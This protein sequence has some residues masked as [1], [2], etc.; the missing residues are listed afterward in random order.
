MDTITIVILV[1]I[2]LVVIL[3]N[4]NKGEPKI[5]LVSLVKKPHQ[6]SDWICYHLNIGFNK[7][8]LIFDDPNDD[9]IS[10]A[11]KFNKVEVIL[12]NDEWK[13]GFELLKNWK[14]HGKHL[15]QEVMSRQ[16]LSVEKTLKL[17]MRDELDWLMHIDSDEILYIPSGNSVSSLYQN[18]TSNIQIVNVD[19]Y[20]VIP[21]DINTTNCFR[22]HTLF[23]NRIVGGFKAYWGNKSS[24]RVNTKNS[25]HGVHYFKTT[26][27]QSK[28]LSHDQALILHYV[29]CNFEEWKQK[30]QILGNFENKW[31]GW[32]PIKLPFHTKSRD[33]ISQYCQENSCNDTELLK[34]YKNELS[35]DS[36][37]NN[38]RISKIDQVQKILNTKC[39]FSN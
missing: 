38:K 1:I 11:K 18:L 27:G 14:E 3:C 20:E 22:N 33:I 35:P 37:I 12:Y 31:W 34:F 30:Y 21:H 39:N 7:I 9:S 23:R 29:N 26:F 8:Y 24:C 2:C 16:V 6:L 13:K 25:P 15:N 36:I 19:N 5:G 4:K 28:N 10:T 32:K 17:A